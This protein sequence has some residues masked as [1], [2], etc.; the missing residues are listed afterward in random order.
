MCSFAGAA[1]A[2]VVG[3]VVGR[4]PAQTNG[5]LLVS[6]FHKFLPEHH[7]RFRILRVVALGMETQKIIKRGPSPVF[8]L[9]QH[10]IEKMLRDAKLESQATL[11]LRLTQG[12]GLCQR[13]A[14]GHNLVH[15][16]KIGHIGGKPASGDWLDPDQL[17]IALY[18]R[19]GVFHTE[20]RSAFLSGLP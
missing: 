8:S 6:G 5:L 13:I 12:A 2:F 14:G 4:F 19:M 20:L 7:D 17:L 3:G 16:H 15:A 11:K 18:H 10:T 9:G 1:G